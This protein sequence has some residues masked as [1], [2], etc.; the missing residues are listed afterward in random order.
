MDRQKIVNALNEWMR[1]YTED[2]A[3]FEAE[4]QTVARFLS[5]LDGG[6]PPSYGETSMAYLEQIMAEQA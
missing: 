1:R 3:S 2:P 6:L 5:E 4:F